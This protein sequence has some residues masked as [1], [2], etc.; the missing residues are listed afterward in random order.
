MD[1]LNN[2]KNKYV[3]NNILEK[4]KSNENHRRSCEE[5]IR[6]RAQSASNKAFKKEQNIEPILYYTS[7]L[8]VKDG[9]SSQKL[10]SAYN[11]FLR[12]M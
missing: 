3:F 12:K 1:E 4:S 2:S 7:E 10:Y 11:S 9:K 5:A 8:M 6:L